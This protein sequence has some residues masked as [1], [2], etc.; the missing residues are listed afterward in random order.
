MWTLKART[1]PPR[2]RLLGVGRRRINRLCTQTRVAE[3][4]A[5]GFLDI[6]TGQ[7]DLDR[8]ADFAAVGGDAGQMRHGH[9]I[10]LL[11][12]GR[13]GM[14]ARH[15]DYQRQPERPKTRA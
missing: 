4:Q 13:T 6:L 1:G 14:K 9:A 11:A 15:D 2:G 5:R 7:R 3:Q 12:V 8:F 10:R